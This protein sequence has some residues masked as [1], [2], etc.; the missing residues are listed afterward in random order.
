MVV[1]S[2][3]AIGL[4][5]LLVAL[6]A[7]YGAL[8]FGDVGDTYRPAAFKAALV[9]VTLA[10]VVGW[11][12]LW[13][14]RVGALALAIGAVVVVAAL[15][16]AAAGPMP[17][18]SHL[19]S[20]PALAASVGLLSGILLAER[21]PVWAAGAVAAAGAPGVVLTSLM[22][23]AA[24]AAMGIAGGYGAAGCLA[25]TGLVAMPLLVM[26]LGAAIPSN[27]GDSSKG[28]VCFLVLV[29]ARRTR[30]VGARSGGLVGLGCSGL[31]GER[32]LVVD[33]ALVAEAGVR[34]A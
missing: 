1:A 26:V 2:L 21:H 13:R 23:R 25:V 12:V 4:W 30:A 24:L 27:R 31:V 33:G 29:G 22:G 10:L 18:L 17:G 11:F 3:A 6:R 20:L 15:G 19:G 9:T 14:R 32:V 7:Q 5:Q 16:V 34:A 8:A 28:V